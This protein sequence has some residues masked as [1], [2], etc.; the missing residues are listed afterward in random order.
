MQAF[1][2]EDDNKDP[3]MTLEERVLDLQKKKSEGKKQM[4]GLDVM[5]SLGI[6]LD[7]DE[8]EKRATIDIWLLITRFKQIKFNHHSD[9]QLKK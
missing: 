3:V 4:T 1:L 8:V 6:A 2:D 5:R 7:E 9:F